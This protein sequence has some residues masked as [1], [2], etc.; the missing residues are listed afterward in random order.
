VRFI[1]PAGD[2]LLIDV[3]TEADFAAAQALWGAG[4]GH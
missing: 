2:D 4:Y 1:D 3:D